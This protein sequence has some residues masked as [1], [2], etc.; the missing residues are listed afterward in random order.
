M[1]EKL[2]IPNNYNHEIISYNLNSCYMY[3]TNSRRCRRTIE[4][5]EQLS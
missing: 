4:W 3:S 2:Q 1:L 5:L